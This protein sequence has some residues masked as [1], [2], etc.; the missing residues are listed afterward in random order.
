MAGRK[1]IVTPVTDP[2]STGGPKRMPFPVKLPKAKPMPLGPIQS[3]A[4]YVGPGVF[5]IK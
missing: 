3:A 2:S 4:P 5:I 1:L